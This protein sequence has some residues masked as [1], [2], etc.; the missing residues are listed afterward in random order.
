MKF[1]VNETVT[2]E[3]NFYVIEKEVDGIGWV[4]DSRVFEVK[5]E[6]MEEMEK[7]QPNKDVKNKKLSPTMQKVMNKLNK[8]DWYYKHNGKA[9]GYFVTE[10]RVR[11]VGFEGAG[12]V[13]GGFVYAQMDSKTLEALRVRGLIE[14]AK[15]GGESIDVMKVVGMEL[16]ERLT[17]A[18]HFRARRYW[19]GKLVQDHKDCYA[20]NEKAIEFAR[21]C[22]TGDKKEV[23]IEIEVYGEVE[24]SVWDYFKTK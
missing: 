20:T 22:F 16:P 21:V 7:R 2:A 13:E 11:S 10:D 6:A 24:L 4:S 9:C 14:V 17:K 5:A 23:T 18:I 8:A 12:I 15:V 19:D 1:R 3:L